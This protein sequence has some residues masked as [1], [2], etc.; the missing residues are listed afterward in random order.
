MRTESQTGI[1]RGKCRTGGGKMVDIARRSIRQH[2]LDNE[3]I[4]K[5]VAEQNERMGFV[6][7]PTATPEKAQEMMRALGIRPE[8][9]LFSRGIIAAREE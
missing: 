2:F 9:N 8:D 5:L 6:P 7:D 1:L 3:P 4:R